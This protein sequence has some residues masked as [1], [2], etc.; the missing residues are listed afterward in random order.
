M[1]CY[2]NITV[3]VTED[4]S[5]EIWVTNAN[6]NQGPESYYQFFAAGTNP[7][8]ATLGGDDLARDHAITIITPKGQ[9]SISGVRCG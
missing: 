3:S 6:W 7:Y 4:I 5:G 2:A 1:G 8:T 9:T